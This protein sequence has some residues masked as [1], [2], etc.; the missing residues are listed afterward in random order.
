MSGTRITHNDTRYP[1]VSVSTSRIGF[2]KTVTEESRVDKED[3]KSRGVK[4]YLSNE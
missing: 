2:M 4:D 1:S 3:R